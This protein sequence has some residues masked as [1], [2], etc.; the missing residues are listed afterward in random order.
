MPSTQSKLYDLEDRLRE[1]LQS[2]GLNQAQV[3]ALIQN[4]G[5]LTRQDVLDFDC[6]QCRC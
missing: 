1:E 5:G 2:G 3:E 6:C 4:S